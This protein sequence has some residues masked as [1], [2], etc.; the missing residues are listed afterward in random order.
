MID[1]ILFPESEESPRARSFA[2][3]IDRSRVRRRQPQ[4]Q[5]Y[6]ASQGPQ[7]SDSF[8]VLSTSSRNLLE[9]GEVTAES[10]AHPESVAEYEKYFHSHANLLSTKGLP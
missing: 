9:K 7:G 1:E 3:T 6:A 10:H 4:T 8:I 2:R 5:D